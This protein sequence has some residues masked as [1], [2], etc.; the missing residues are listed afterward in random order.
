MRLVFLH[1]FPPLAIA[2]LALGLLAAPVG[3]AAERPLRVRK[4]HPRLF[5]TSDQLQA[6]AQSARGPLVAAYRDHVR[7]DSDDAYDE[8]RIEFTV[9]NAD[10]LLARTLSLLTCARIEKRPEYSA[11]AL[12]LV[13]ALLAADQE[14]GHRAAR[15]RIQTLAVAYDWLHA[16]LAPAE[17]V[18]LRKALEAR[19]QDEA[20]ALETQ[21]EYVSGHSHFTTSSL[22]LTAIALCDGTGRWE[23]EL[24]RALAH[25]EGYLKVARVVCADGGHHLGWRYGRSYAARLVLVAEAVTRATSLDL[26]AREKAWLSQLGYHLIYGLR[27]DNTYFR[28]GDSHRGVRAGIDDDLIVLGILAARY[29]NVHYAQAGWKLIEWCLDNPVLVP[30]CDF[31]FPLLFYPPGLEKSPAPPLP[32]VRGFAMAGNYVFRS[33]WGPQDTVVLFRAMPWYH[34]NH[35]HRDFGSFTIFSRGSL[36]IDSG[37]Y[38]TNDEESDYGGSHLRNYAWRT[39]AHNSILVFDPEERFC[40]PTG[41]QSERCTGEGRWA[42]DGGQKIRSRTNDDVTVPAYQPRD[43]GDILDPR[44]A[45]GAV[46]AFED[47]PEAAYVSAD[48]TKAYRS[49]K[50]ALWERSLIFL[51]KV[52]GAADPV[53]VLYD[54]VVSKRPELKKT[55]LL[56]TVAEPRRDG[57]AFVVED[58]RRV[59]LSGDLTGKPKDLWHEYGGRLRVETLLPAGAMAEFVGGEGKE[60]WVDGKNYGAEVREVDAVV[61]PGDGRIEVSPSQPALADDFLHVLLPSSLAGPEPRCETALLEG[62][63]PACRVGD[64]VIV[65]A[66]RGEGVVEYKSP[67]SERST[68]YV[69]GLKPGARHDVLKDKKRIQSIVSSSAGSILFTASGGGAFKI[70]RSS[71]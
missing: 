24:A 5:I 67:G 58:C 52:E 23:A 53:V 16:E 30:H 37:V 34:F 9:K 4:E 64:H 47:R 25:W 48:G 62:K 19:Y 41:P 22:I 46:L 6:L 2:V 63:T 38:Q 33:G 49:S 13:R 44:F 60:C 51:R 71:R 59:R 1:P 11:K 31:I 27:P 66:R 8:R 69:V 35:E 21:T 7:R 70:S 61:E 43:A 14:A 10:Y 42:N 54:R 17:R 40:A 29:R 45:Q 39:V 57:S 12:S 56:H 28:V 55:W 20:G 18:E 3:R 65:V 50:L 36:A 26:F 32:G 15:L 68:H